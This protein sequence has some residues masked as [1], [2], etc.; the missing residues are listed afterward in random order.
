MKLIIAFS[1]LIILVLIAVKPGMA[2]NS[3]GNLSGCLL[4]SNCVLVEWSFPNLKNAYKG[5]V[6]IAS[7]L[8]RVNEVESSQNYWHG[9]VRS[10]IFRFP[11]D[12]EILRIDSRNIIQVRSASRIGLSDLGVNQKRVDDLY[13][14]LMEE[15]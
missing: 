7:S 14:Q 12:L 13:L 8:P 11:D 1:Q 15:I 10:L 6:S 3:S 9:I 5:L 4:P 2:L